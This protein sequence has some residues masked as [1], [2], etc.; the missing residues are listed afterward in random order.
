MV[1]P[2]MVGVTALGANG[3]DNL[4]AYLTLEPVADDSAPR[5]VML[6]M[7]VNV[8]LLITPWTSLATLLWHERC[9]AGPGAVS[10]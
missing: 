4:P 9:R 8:G 2:R 7:G 3:V 10:E 6:L 1:Y 5:S